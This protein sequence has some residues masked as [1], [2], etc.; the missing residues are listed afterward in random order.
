MVI[1]SRNGHGNLS[2]NPGLFVFDRVL[3]PLGKLWVNS[4]AD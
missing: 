4:R 3:I 2:S 1:V